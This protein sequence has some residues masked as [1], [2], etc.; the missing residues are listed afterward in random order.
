MSKRL[1]SVFDLEVTY[2]NNIMLIVSK[3]NQ[4][5]LASNINCMIFN[6]R[7]TG[8]LHRGPLILSNLIYFGT[9]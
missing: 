9:I 1:R 4:P 2:V 7:Y 3:V 8:T 6:G 5:F